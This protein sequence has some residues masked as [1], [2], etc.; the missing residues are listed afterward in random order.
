MSQGNNPI[1]VTRPS[2]GPIPEFDEYLEQMWESG[3][4]THNGPLLQRLERELMAYLKVRNMVCVVNGTAALDLAIRAYDLQGEIITSPFSFIATANIIDWNR[5]KPVFVDI[6]PHTWNIDPEK[7]EDAI[8]DRTAAIL[9]VHVFSAPC[10]VEALQDIADRHNLKLIYDSA[11]ATAVEYKGRPL[12]EY[13]DVSCLSFHATKLYNTGEG[14][15]CV[16]RDDE[17]VDRIKRLR[18]FG[19]DDSKDIVDEGTN[20]KMTE[21]HAA[22]GLVNLKY[23]DEVR[24]DRKRKYAYYQKQLAASPFIDFQRFEEESYNYSYMPVLFDSEE[25]LL[26]AVRKLG[27]KKIFPRRYFYPSL[28]RVRGFMDSA[29]PIAE[30]IAERILCLPL[31]YDLTTEEIDQIVKIIIS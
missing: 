28:N 23:L 5:I 18:F 16:C 14:G 2:L 6:D 1:F 29:L 31:Y 19:F 22:L 21:I 8:T 7:V 17:I 20:A 10:D 24:A 3:I 12:V 25:R 4:L 30:S 13:G 26:D 27:A 15:G 9:P 11:H